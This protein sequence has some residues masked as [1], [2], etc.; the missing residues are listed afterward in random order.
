VVGLLGWLAA[1]AA[2]VSAGGLGNSVAASV[3]DRGIGVRAEL[4]ERIFEVFASG[5]P[6]AA[7][8]TRPGAGI[9]LDL[10]RAI[11]T[12]PGGV[13]CMRPRSGGGSCFELVLPLE[14]QLRER[15]PPGDS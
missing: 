9:G 5:K 6:V 13:I 15:P 12:A 14:A 7:A 1:S 11:A 2:A 10:C 3:R 8:A 4:R